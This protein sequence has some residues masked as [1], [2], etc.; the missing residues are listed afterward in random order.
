M[1]GLGDLFG[2][3]SIAE[4]FLLWGV[5]QQLLQPLLEPVITEISKE[6]NSKFPEL[7]LTPAELAGQVARGLLDDS[8][9]AGEASQSGLGATEFAKLVKAAAQSPALGTAVAAFQRGEIPAGDGD[10]LTPSLTGALADAG[11]RREWWPIVERLAVQI[12]STAEVMNA[13]LEGQITEAEA[14]TRYLAAGG[15]PTWFQTSYN[16]NGQAPTPVEAL[17]L[18]NRGIIPQDG[19]GPDSI[20]YHQAFLE[21]PWR[22]KWLTPFLALR[23][24]LP[25]PRTVTAMFHD[26]QLTH[27]QAAELLTKQGL[28]PDLVAAYLSPT[29][30]TT[31]TT[32]KHLAKTDILALYTDGLMTSADATKALEAINYT[33]HDAALIIELQDVRIA[34]AQVSAGV[35]RVRGLFNSGKITATEAAAELVKLHVDAAQATELVN[36][37]AITTSNEVRTLTASQI[38]RAWYYLLISADDAMTRLQALGYDAEDAYVLLGLEAKGPVP[39]LPNPLPKFTPPPLPPVTP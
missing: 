13:W 18:L 29:S 12:P 9:A 6:V 28:A 24:Y 14:R 34:A 30:S 17:E 16:A 26:G 2:R 3:G 5:L 10:P 1:P 33:A 4:Q 8:D 19:T 36:T 11:V 37:W 22:N 27:A 25:P 20:S 23:E 21:G 32:E 31:S 38:G 35:T 15:D 7:P 39:G